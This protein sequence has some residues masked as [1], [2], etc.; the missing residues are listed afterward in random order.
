MVCIYHVTY[1][2]IKHHS[3]WSWSYVLLRITFCVNP[4][5]TS[6][7][8][9]QGPAYVFFLWRIS[10]F[11]KWCNHFYLCV[12]TAF[13]TVLYFGTNNIV[14]N[15]AEPFNL[16][17]QDPLI[18][19]E[20]GTQILEKWVH[21]LCLFFIAKSSLKNVKVL[22]FRNMKEYKFRSHIYI[23][24]LQPAVSGL[25]KNCNYIESGPTMVK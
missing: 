7:F 10:R 22:S 25:R 9:L 21:L 20:A 3:L 11:P 1:Y 5:R 8:I 15:K 19:P 2:F 18:F 23:I 16:F 12:S 6:L 4:W 13:L 24:T 17:N 14:L